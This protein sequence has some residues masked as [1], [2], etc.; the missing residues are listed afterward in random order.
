LPLLLQGSDCARLARVDC[1]SHIDRIVDRSRTCSAASD[2][3]MSH[4]LSCIFGLFSD[5]DSMTSLGLGGCSMCRA[6]IGILPASSL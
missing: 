5:I 3:A 4:T 1:D 2:V 6:Y